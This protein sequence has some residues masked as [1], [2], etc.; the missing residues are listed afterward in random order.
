MYIKFCA[1]YFKNS[2]SFAKYSLNLF[3]TVWEFKKGLIFSFAWENCSFLCGKGGIF[4]H[5]KYEK[6]KELE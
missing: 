4:N 3:F 5:S 1:M 6:K 2:K